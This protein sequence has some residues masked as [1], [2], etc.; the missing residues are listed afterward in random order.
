MDSRRI[1]RVDMDWKL[2]GGVFGFSVVFIAMFLEMYKKIIRKDRAKDWEGQVLAF[3][4]SLGL[5]MAA[6]FG[7]VHP[8][9][10]W[11]L[12]FLYFGVLYTSQFTLDMLLIKKIGKA[13]AA[14]LLKQRGVTLDGFD[15][16][17]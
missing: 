4:F 2:L 5:T 3:V 11:P 16:N 8:G 6:Y 1:G 14:S 10:K 7:L 13:V 17:D 12:C 15:W 9:I